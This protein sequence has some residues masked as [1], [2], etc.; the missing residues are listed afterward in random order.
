MAIFSMPQIIYS[1]KYTI[2]FELIIFQKFFRFMFFFFQI[3]YKS[4]PTLKLNQSER[5]K[6]IDKLYSRIKRME[7][8][9]NTNITY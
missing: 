2:G 1:L 8:K 3:L 9:L 7:K 5:E 6:K 4:C